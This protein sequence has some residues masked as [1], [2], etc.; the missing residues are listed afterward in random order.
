MLW[1]VRW[2]QSMLLRTVAL[3]YVGLENEAISL[4]PGTLNETNISVNRTIRAAKPCRARAMHQGFRFLSENLSFV[5][6][7]E[8]RLAFSGV[9]Q[10]HWG[11]EVN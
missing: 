4:E 1:V 5:E 10:G 6:F 8:A 7:Q 9:L 2:L 3:Y 11:D